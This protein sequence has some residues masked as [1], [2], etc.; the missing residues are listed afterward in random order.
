MVFRGWSSAVRARV[1]ESALDRVPGDTS[2]SA[3]PVGDPRPKV[4]AVMAA[5]SIAALG[6]LMLLAAACGSPASTSTSAHASTKLPSAGVST[7][8]TTPSAFGTVATIT[9]TSMEVQNPQTGQ[10]TVGWTSSTVF[11]QTQ[12]ATSAAVVSGSCI[13]VTGT[14]PAA[15][16]STGPITAT[17]ITIYQPGAAGSC[18]PGAAGGAAGGAGFP[19]GRFQG[20]GRAT[21]GGFPGG[22]AASRRSSGGHGPGRFAFVVGKVVTASG[23]GI[24]VQGSLRA[25]RRPGGRRASTPQ[26]STL[27]KVITSSATVYQQIVPATSSDL[28]VGKCVLARGPASDTGSIAAVVVSISSAGPGGCVASP[29]HRRFPGGG[30]FGAGGSAGPSAGLG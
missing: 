19:A 23:A 1:P 28:A 7:R 4:G 22:Q 13:T 2:R 17:S 21:A 8:P 25:G 20:A 14:P 5:C 12:A 16:G 24:S 10:V 27:L 15:S 29:G 11:T 30:S 6:A 9:A 3:V 26:P 18:A